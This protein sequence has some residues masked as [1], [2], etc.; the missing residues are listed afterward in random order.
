MEKEHTLKM[1]ELDSLTSAPHM[2]MIKAAL[3]Y[4]HI[5][6]QRFFSLIVKLSELER[7]IR[8]FDR[9]DG[10]AMGICSLGDDE[11]SSPIDML[12]AMKPYGTEEEQD[13]IDLMINFMQGA[14]LSQSYREMQAAEQHGGE[15]PEDNDCTAQEASESRSAD[16][17]QGTQG[18]S[19]PRIPFEY[20]KGMLPP[21]Q[22][23]RLE[24]MQMLM[25]AFRPNPQQSSY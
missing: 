16:V 12:S 21:E 15:P 24:T 7:T 23:A 17:S 3:P 22:Q 9:R 25:Q 19:G 4:I 18:A 13:M 14:R 6:E 20:L 11:P 10:E 2:Q 1:T 8:L 5:P